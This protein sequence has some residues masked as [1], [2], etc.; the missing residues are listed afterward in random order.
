MKRTFKSPDES[1]RW[2]AQQNEAWMCYEAAARLWREMGD[3][4]SAKRCEAR[5]TKMPK[6]GV[7]KFL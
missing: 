5:C 2:L 4:E 3:E 1:K 7:A 6:D